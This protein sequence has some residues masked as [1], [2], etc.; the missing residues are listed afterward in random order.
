MS[1]VLSSRPDCLDLFGG[2]F[3]WAAAFSTASN[4]KMLIDAVSQSATEQTG[5]LR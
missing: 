3:G 2:E 4:P 1:A 5:D